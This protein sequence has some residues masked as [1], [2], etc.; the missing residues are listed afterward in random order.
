MELQFCYERCDLGMNICRIIVGIRGSTSGWC[1]VV[2]TAYRF[3][4]VIG[5]VLRIT[6]GVLVRKFLVVTVVFISDSVY[7]KK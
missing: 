4:L 1:V 3:Q 5:V 6:Y 2:F 7:S